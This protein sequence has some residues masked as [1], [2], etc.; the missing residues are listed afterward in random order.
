MSGAE[1]DLL[2]LLLLLLL[3]PCLALPWDARACQL[4]T[5]PHR[6]TRHSALFPRSLVT[7][8]SAVPSLTP[9]LRGSGLVAM[10]DQQDGTLVAGGNSSSLF[11]W[12]MVQERISTKIPTRADA[13]VTSLAAAQ[14]SAS[15]LSTGMGS[16]PAFPSSAGS[17]P[18][19]PV[20]GAAAGLIVTGNGDGGI[21]VYDQ[22]M[23]PQIA[24]VSTFSEHR[25]WV[26]HCSVQRDG[27]TMG[28]FASC[29]CC[30]CCCCCCGCCRR[31]RCFDG[32][33]DAHSPPPA[34]TAPS[35]RRSIRQRA[36]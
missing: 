28:E 6:S 1:L 5:R 19:N 16:P 8:F 31:C 32:A 17:S 3:L 26:V 14:S 36:R 27:N 12:D 24:L 30:C 33:A 25:A 20:A 23:P 22:R 9:S 29:C 10:W 35:A 2:L 18:L 4:L 21:R 11:V 13:C 15:F 34:P 7:A